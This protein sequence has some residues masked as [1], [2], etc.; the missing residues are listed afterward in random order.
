MSERPKN[1]ATVYNK[2]RVVIRW[3]ERHGFDATYEG[4]R[5]PVDIIATDGERRWFIRVKYTRS[6]E[7]GPERSNKEKIPLIRMA[8]KQGG[9]AVLCFVVQNSPWLDSTRTGENPARGFL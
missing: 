4:G 9:T 6:A 5:G 7:M 3:L 8:N 2:E 1:T